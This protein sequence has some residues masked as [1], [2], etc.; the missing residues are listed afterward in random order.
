MIVPTDAVLVL[1]YRKKWSLSRIARHLRDNNYPIDAVQLAFEACGFHTEIERGT[2][3]KY[4]KFQNLKIVDNSFRLALAIIGRI[5]DTD[6]RVKRDELADEVHRIILYLI[7]INDTVGY[8]S[9]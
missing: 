2:I 6:D 9:W 8:V 1:R 7:T 5:E 3:L 4:Y